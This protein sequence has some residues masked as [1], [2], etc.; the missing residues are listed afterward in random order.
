MIQISENPTEMRE[1]F[2][3]FLRQHS[4]QFSMS[5]WISNWDDDKCNNVPTVEKFEKCGTS[6]C[7]GGALGIIFNPNNN[8]MCFE[9][10]LPKIGINEEAE[11]WLF[12]ASEWPSDFCE[13]YEKARDKEDGSDFTGMVEAA[14]KAIDWASEEYPVEV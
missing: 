1:N 12:Y 3:N 7:I 9:D 10:Y 2:K 6:C 11:D 8:S 4:K 5:D 14:C 13:E